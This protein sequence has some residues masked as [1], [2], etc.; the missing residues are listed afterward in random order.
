MLYV[1]VNWDVVT[2]NSMVNTIKFIV[3]T[4]RLHK[5]CDATCGNTVAV[6]SFAMYKGAYFRSI[7]NV[8]CHAIVHTSAVLSNTAKAV[9][10]VRQLFSIYYS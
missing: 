5:V 9:I 7:L 1:H 10:L 8:I 6:R 3:L 2:L 4:T